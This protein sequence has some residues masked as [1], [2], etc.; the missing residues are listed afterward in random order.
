VRLGNVVRECE[1]AE[2]VQ[3]GRIVGGGRIE[4][5]LIWGED[6][7]ENTRSEGLEGY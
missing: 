1:G 3:K 6:E 5:I 4:R 2:Y 7:K